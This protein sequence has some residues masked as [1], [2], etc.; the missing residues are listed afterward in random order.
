MYAWCVAELSRTSEALKVTLQQV[1]ELQL[2]I[3]QP[4]V[5]AVPTIP[6]SEAVITANNQAKG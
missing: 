2:T 1:Q 6:P 5:I 3:N 4:Q